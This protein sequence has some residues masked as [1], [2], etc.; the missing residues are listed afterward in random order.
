MFWRRY[1]LAA[2]TT[3]SKD[4]QLNNHESLFEF[5]L[6]SIYNISLY[7]H[8]RRLTFFKVFLRSFCHEI[9]RSIPITVND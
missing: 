4:F 7:S 5:E 3:T 6:Y 1:F 8:K 9:L 2:V